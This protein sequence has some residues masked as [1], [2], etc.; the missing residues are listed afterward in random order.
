MGSPFTGLQHQYAVPE[1]VHT[2]N[3]TGTV[4]LSWELQ[5]VRLNARCEFGRTGLREDRLQGER[6]EEK[7]ARTNGLLLKAQHCMPVHRLNSGTSG[8]LCFKAGNCF[9]SRMKV[10]AANGRHKAS[11]SQVYHSGAILCNEAR[12]CGP[13]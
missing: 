8:S 1:R 9:Y 7:C 13:K 12:R 11:L 3:S 4:P 6:G 5:L 2:R 10:G